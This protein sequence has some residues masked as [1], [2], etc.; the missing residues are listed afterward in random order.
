MAALDAETLTEM[1]AEQAERRA[2][3]IAV[4]DRNVRLTYAEL[5]AL[6][7][8]AA[9]LIASGAPSAGDA[10]PVGL[11]LNRSCGLVAGAL[12]IMRAGRP[13]LPLDPAQPDERLRTIL[14]DA[15]CTAVLTSAESA[16]RVSGL[17][18]QAVLLE[19]A[20]GFPP[21]DLPPISPA[22][23]AYVVYTSGSTGEPKGVLV[24]HRQVARLITTTDRLFD[25]RPDDV[26]AF[27]H[28][29]AFDASVWEIWG[30]LTR[31]ARLVVVPYWTSRS[32][33][34][35]LALLE[36]ERVTVTAQTQSAFQA[37]IRADLVE[38]ARA[39]LSLRYVFLGGEKLDFKVLRPWFAGRGDSAP[40]VFNMY[41]PTE[42][43]VY[44]TYRRVRSED[45]GGEASLIGRP[46]PDLDVAVLGPHG[47]PVADGAV[48]DLHISGPGLARGYLGRE[49]LTAE[50]YPVHRGRRW[51]RTGDL[52]RRTPEGE[53]EYLGRID[54]QVQVRGFR[55][56]LGEVE[57][58]LRL[59]P[60]VADCAVAARTD[61]ANTTALA[62][63]VVTS[64]T[65]P[66]LAGE[67]R[68]QLAL[69]LPGYMVPS[70]FTRVESLPLNQNGK[71]DRAALPDPAPAAHDSPSDSPPDSPPDKPVGELEALLCRLWAE[72][73]D[74]AAVGP[75]DDVFLMGGHSV[76]A[77]RVAMRAREAGHQVP[78]RV[79]LSQTSPRAAAEQLA[80]TAG[81]S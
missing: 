79:L 12:G 43:T 30:A 78:L 27:F 57:V 59:H 66:G 58:K 19:D 20:D 41:G 31:G 5:D 3:A 72:A 18:V 28:S 17:G 63:Y 55:V 40:E 80:Q 14:S 51:Y 44:A 67:L 54:D 24:E 2:K 4:C 26:W 49:R 74:V 33:V 22:D 35:Y 52:V 68:D 32:P 65:D 15:A 61:A 71:L 45:T 34:D 25:L 29:P 47:D 77:A 64:R 56:E 21:G 81:L 37:L 38:E 8:R 39:A 1:F 69:H 53:L 7:R 6:S 16:D 10:R 76:M 62:A 46:L 13:Y 70:T 73:L 36:R 50:R 9:A 75:K 48:G 11:L 42:T 23:P 60:D